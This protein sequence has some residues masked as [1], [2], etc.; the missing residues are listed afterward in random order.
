M[1][2]LTLNGSGLTLVA[3]GAATS[4]TVGTTT[5][6]GG[7]TSR[8]LYDNGGVIGE[9]LVRYAAANVTFGDV[10]AAS[11]VAQSINVQNVATG[12]TDTA[13]AN[14][15]INLSQGT[16]TGASGQ[17]L[18]KYAPAGTT[19][20][21]Q[22]ALVNAFVIDTVGG[23]AFGTS[24]ASNAVLRI[25]RNITGATSAYGITNDAVVQSGVTNTGF[26]NRTITAT[27]AAAFTV[28]SFGGYRVEQGT[29]GA[30]STV[31]NQYGYYA[32]SSLTGATNNYA[33]YSDIAS[34]TN[35]FNFYANGT[36]AN[37]FK[38][39]LTIYGA[40]AVPAGG[41]TGS[42]LKFSSTTN[43]GVFFGSGTPSLSA[44]KGSLYLRTD[45]STTNDRMYVNTNGTT[46]WA[47][48]TTAS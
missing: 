8:M 42:G 16:G 4:I 14:L 29:I 25:R 35:R 19:G 48:V 1:A 5:I 34:G 23:A 36:A 3:G 46:G 32:E 6:S 13:G 10:D 27:A 37:L 38:G 15:T 20:S 45:G 47:A 7:V 40:T 2:G 9:A 33:F 44:A 21:A 18:V 12:T 31:T 41:T 26:N 39:D 17:F 11:P 43:L 24:T 30:G 22:N 28:T